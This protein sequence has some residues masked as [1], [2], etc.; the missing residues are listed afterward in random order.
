[1][2]DALCNHSVLSAAL[3]CILHAA[4]I[5]HKPVI[6]LVLTQ[7]RSAPWIHTDEG[8]DDMPGHVKC[9]M[10]GASLNIPL[11]KGRL[12]LGTWQVTKTFLAEGC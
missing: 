12:N 4:Y 10:F 6:I 1:M 9:S 8:D 3:K 7:G 2:H 11:T 5:M